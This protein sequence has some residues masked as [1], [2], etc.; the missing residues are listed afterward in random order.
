LRAAGF[1]VAAVAF[2]ASASSPSLAVDP[3][4]VPHHGGFAAHAAAHVEDSD[5][6]AN[7]AGDRF[8]DAA[9]S[10]MRAASGTVGV[11]VRHAIAW[12]EGGDRDQVP[13]AVP[14]PPSLDQL[15]DAFASRKTSDA[16]QDCLA[17]AVYFEARGEPIQGQL[18]VAEVVLNRAASGKYPDSLCGV[19]KQK[20]QFSFVSKGRFPKANK[21]S[22]A[23]RKSV[24]IARIAEAGIAKALSRDVLWYHADY[25][26]PT[27]G[28]RLNRE[29]QI[30]LHIFYS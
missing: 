28:S 24:A 27:W 8:A 15:V 1:A 6:A 29:T 2:I 9:R 11:V 12:L 3:D 22:D 13:A 23:W 21:K 7:D 30:G 10:G 17:N 20:A 26:A 4:S 5:L 19:V 25:V 16:E 14:A 18:A